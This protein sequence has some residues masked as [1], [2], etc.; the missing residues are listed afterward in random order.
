M[1]D[2]FGLNSAS[3]WI[4]VFEETSVAF[5]FFLSCGAPKTG[6][7]GVSLVGPP[8]AG[9]VVVVKRRGPRPG[10]DKLSYIH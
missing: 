9:C 3:N 7:I 1:P 4:D 6:R 5:G 10:R 8:L 2:T